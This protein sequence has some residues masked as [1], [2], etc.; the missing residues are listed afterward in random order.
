MP[1]NKF[2]TTAQF[3][4]KL[5]LELATVLHAASRHAVSFCQILRQRIR[6]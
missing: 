1:N 3:C 5:R 2:L 6:L 4:F